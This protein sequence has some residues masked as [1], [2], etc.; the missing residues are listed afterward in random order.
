[1]ACFLALDSGGTKTEAVLFDENGHMLYRGITPG[2][3]AMDIGYDECC[4]RGE[5]AIALA[6]H[7]GAMPLA[8]LYAG[9]AGTQPAGPVLETYLRAHVRSDSLRVED[10]GPAMISSMLGHQDG[11]CVVCGTGSSLFARIEGRPELIHIGGCGYL[12]DTGGSGFE[13][14]RDVLKAVF[15]ADDG[16]GPETLLLGLFKQKYPQGPRKSMMAIYSGGR[17]YIAKFSAMAFEAVQEGDEVARAI[18]A[19]GVESLAELVWAASRYFPGTFSVVLGGGVFAHH[20]S[21]AK[22]VAEKAPGKARMLIADVP[23]VYGAA[24]EALF[25]AGV[26]ES[27]SFREQF[28]AEY[29]LWCSRE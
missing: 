6:T 5:H 11:C 10:D 9:I 7:D 17:P 19:H 15:R 4:R 14:G 16:R 22:A 18:I 26:S 28:L 8:S 29:G 27:P 20:P 12:I 1:M 21:Y 3:N 25:D 24:R 2:A 23:P 13:L